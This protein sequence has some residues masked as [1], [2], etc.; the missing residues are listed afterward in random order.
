MPQSWVSICNK[1]IYRIGLSSFITN[2]QKDDTKV[3]RACLANYESIR[4]EVLEGW[5]WKCAV[6][7]AV[8]VKDTTAPAFGY[9][10]RYL[11]PENPYCLV[12][13]EMRPHGVDYV[14]EGRYLLTNIDS[15]ITPVMIRYTA[16][17][18]DPTLLTALV[19]KCIAYRL[20]AEIAPALSTVLNLQ[21][22]IMKEYIGFAEEAEAKNQ[23]YDFDHNSD[24]PWTNL[25]GVYRNGV[26]VGIDDHTIEL[27]QDN[28][29]N[30]V[31]AGEWNATH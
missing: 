26:F 8:L 20:A 9:K 23:M 13:R 28:Q 24:V 2:L 10:F 6:G 19:A 27:L 4:D 16:R 31:N 21:A 7:R 5:D 15:D 29:D 18:E 12:P 1:S 25:N 30:W 22:S 17:I 14:I 11:L 3:S